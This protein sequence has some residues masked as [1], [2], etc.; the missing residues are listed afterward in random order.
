MP[1]T[2]NG[3]SSVSRVNNNIGFGTPAGNLL[4]NTEFGMA[5]DFKENSA[6]S[7]A[8]EYR[9]NY[10]GTPFNFI[11]YSRNSTATY[12]NSGG[13][14]V[15]ANVNEPRITYDSVSG[16]I[17][18][19][20]LEPARTNAKANSEN[21]SLWTVQFNPIFANTRVEPYTAFTAPD[22][23]SNARVLISNA[24][25]NLVSTLL[26]T[27]YQTGGFAWGA[28][29]FFYKKLSA[30]FMHI[31]VITHIYNNITRSIIVDLNTNTVVS[32]AGNSTYKGVYIEPHIDGWYRIT[33]V[34]RQDVSTFNPIM[35]FIGDA[36]IANPTRIN[37]GAPQGGNSIY[38]TRPADTN[39]FAIF[40]FQVEDCG[41]DINQAYSTSYIRTGTTVVTRAADVAFIETSNFPYNPNEGTIIVKSRT[42]YPIANNNINPTANGALIGFTSTP[43]A[44][45]GYYLSI[46]NKSRSNGH[47][48]FYKEDENFS[49]ISSNSNFL[50]TI[51]NSTNGIINVSV[52][53]AYN[54]TSFLLS[55]N[56]NV[57]TSLNG[58]NLQPFTHLFFGNRTVNAFSQFNVSDHIESVI[59]INRALSNT[60][61]QLKTL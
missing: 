23:S 39:C 52:G 41:T 48:I 28:Y 1:I 33:I 57:T 40:G 30:D 51:A 59:Y 18:G 6:V 35:V 54:S 10:S 37:F 2:L 42:P 38:V 50:M 24:G 21:I 36:Q 25:T 4:G 20:V 13:Y 9:Y 60:E 61:L 27:E 44:A 55:A 3:L 58:A 43:A 31:R 5:I 12:V 47:T 19:L 46:S 17:K 11:K 29:S 56:G 53:L 45:N 22:G 16:V 32:N 14:L 49:T 26:V 7:R 8:A 15:T 34:V